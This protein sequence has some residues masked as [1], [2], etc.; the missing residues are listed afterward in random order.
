MCVWL[1]WKELRL[2]GRIWAGTGWEA[3][4]TIIRLLGAL[5]LLQPFLSEAPSIDPS[6]Q[7]LLRGELQ[8]LHT[9]LV[10]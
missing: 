9:F 8:I 5:S 4:Y 1:C 2:L 3:L 6:L 10:L 7:H